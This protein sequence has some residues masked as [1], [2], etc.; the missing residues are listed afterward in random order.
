MPSA[1][2][3]FQAWLVG[4]LSA[5]KS[6]ASHAHSP[7]SLDQLDFEETQS[8][9]PYDENLLEQSRTQWQ[10]GDWASLTQLTKETLQHHPDRAKLA[11]LAAAGQLQSDNA[12]TAK[13]FI[14]LALDWGCSKTMVSQV[15]VAGVYSTLGT[16]A[17]SG[18]DQQRALGHFKAAAL[19]A[20]KK[21]NSELLA[22]TQVLR[23]SLRIGK[24]SEDNSSHSTSLGWTSA[25]A[26]T[27]NCDKNG[28]CR[29]SGMTIVDI[30]DLGANLATQLLPPHASTFPFDGWNMEREDG[31]ILSYLLKVCNPKRHLEFGTWQGWGTC[32]CLESTAASVW[33]INYPDGETKADGSWAY[34]E[35]VADVASK[36]GVVAETFGDANT[37][38]IIYHRT[39]AGTYVGHMYREKNLGHR[40]CQIYCDSREWDISNYPDDFFDSAFVDGGHQFD[41]VI[42]D[43]RKALSLVRSGGMII[44]H[45][46]CPIKEVYERNA[47]VGEVARALDTLLPEISPL[48]N[49][50][51]WINPSMILVGIKK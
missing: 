15:L 17:V 24:A 28:G 39:D 45:D 18:G 43:T 33:T 35:R 29:F 2:V 49:S 3:H 21:A 41:V 22:E 30:Q 11:L 20:N 32:L 26:L 7:V 13:Q 23:E 46:F 37:G 1:W 31:P 12:S 47:V 14:R 42:S 10:L 4:L 19:V 50:L 8:V 44:W 40:V 16:A 34:G 27:A 48:F 36:P 38:P 9:V 6:V 51:I 25:Q 5:G